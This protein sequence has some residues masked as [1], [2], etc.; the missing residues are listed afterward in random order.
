VYTVPVKAPTDEQLLADY[1]AGDPNAFRV[2]VERH[3]RELYD[4]VFRFTR[5]SAAAEDVVQEAFLQVH[6]SGDSFDPSRRFRPWLFTIAANKSR[7]WL[8]SRSRQKEVALD[9]TIDGTDDGGQRFLDLLADETALPADT[10]AQDEQRRAVRRV[11]DRM[12]PNLCEVL[13]LAYYHRFAYKE[14]ADIL[15]IPLGTVKSRLHAAVAAF[16]K[17]LETERKTSENRQNLSE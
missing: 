13:V 12:P 11:V 10:M 15:D 9:A 2:L 14:I 7:D 3:S 6:L 17:A 5:S 16:A 4:F 8:R 1:L